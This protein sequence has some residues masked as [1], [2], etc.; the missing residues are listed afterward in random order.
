MASQRTGRRFSDLLIE[1][2]MI[3][4]AVVLALAAEEWREKQDRREL[5]ARALNLVTEEIR[6]NLEELERTAPENRER[7]ASAMEVLERLESGE[8]AVE[9]DVGL[10][11]ALLSRAAWQS[12]QMSQA[13]QYFD[14][15]DVRELSEVY[16]VQA[17]F[18]RVQQGMVD[19]MRDMITIAQADP[20]AAVRQGLMGFQMLLGL[21]DSLIEV[22]RNTLRELESGP[23]P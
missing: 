5:A 15:E 7:M 18:E 12:A 17:L 6:S 9:A 1:A 3:F 13:V 4:L 23:A 10:E 20:A 16:E 2:G 19:S 11:V 21:Q 8:E 22:Y 14:L